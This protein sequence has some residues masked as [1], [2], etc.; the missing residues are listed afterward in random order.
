MNDYFN[1]VLSE[2]Q[3]P[4]IETIRKARD[5]HGVFAL[6]WQTFLKLSDYIFHEL[7]I[8]KLN[9]YGFDETSLKEIMSYLKNRTQATEV[10]SSFSE[11]L[12]IIYGIP[13]GSILVLLLFIIYFCGLF[14]VNKNVD[15]SSQADDTTP[16]YYWYEI[17]TNYSWIKKYLVGHPTMLYE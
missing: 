15:F 8:A 9:D 5:N 7:L 17:W 11:L 3:L 16:F 14:I 1:Y 12:N 13:Q 10:E 2:F 6:L 4:M